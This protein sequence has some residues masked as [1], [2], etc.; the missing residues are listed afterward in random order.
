MKHHK[1]VTRKPELQQVSNFQ[2]LKDFMIALTD[3]LVEWV[4]Q[5][6]N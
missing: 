4:F 1:L 3:Q 6:T 5:K 2:V